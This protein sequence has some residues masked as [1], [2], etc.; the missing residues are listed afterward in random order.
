MKPIKDE[1][2]VHMNVDIEQ[3]SP[4]ALYSFVKREN[5]YWWND[6]NYKLETRNIYGS[7]YS[8]ILK[9]VCP[10]QKNKDTESTS[11]LKK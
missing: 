6:K 5:L 4:D 1:P 9:I 2:F 3:D 11:I 8:I 10:P 7:I